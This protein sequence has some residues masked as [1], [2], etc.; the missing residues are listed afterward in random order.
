MTLCEE[1]LAA[2]TITKWIQGNYKYIKFLGHR[3]EI[4]AKLGGKSM[5]RN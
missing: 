2:Q 4:D 5:R 3:G 1:N